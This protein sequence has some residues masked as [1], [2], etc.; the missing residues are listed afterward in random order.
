[1]VT[2]LFTFFF[3]F[4]N[5]Q[6]CINYWI[7]S[8]LCP[9]LSVC[10]LVDLSVVWLVCRLVGVCHNLTCC[11]LP[12]LIIVSFDNS[13]LYPLQ[14]VDHPAVLRRQDPAEQ[15]GHRQGDHCRREGQRTGSLYLSLSLSLPPSPPLSLSLSLSRSTSIN[16]P[17]YLSI[18]L[19]RKTNM[20]I[21][22]Y[23][24]LSILK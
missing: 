20:N 23:I 17:F 2:F 7:L 9:L 21:I 5:S 13:L 10:G 6:P 11:I 1:M 4:I 12:L 18:Y 19:F 16:L 8:C 24:Y 22:V 15:G 14:V 3:S